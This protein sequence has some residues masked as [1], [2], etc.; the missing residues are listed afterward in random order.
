M[1]P[2]PQRHATV[3]YPYGKTGR[4]RLVTGNDGQPT[5]DAR[6]VRH[7]IQ[8]ALDVAVSTRLEP[9]DAPSV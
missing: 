5:F 2:N 4:V 8:E 1:E 3:F 6:A 9:R 7:A